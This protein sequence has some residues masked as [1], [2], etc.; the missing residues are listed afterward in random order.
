MSSITPEALDFPTRWERL[1]SSHQFLVDMEVEMSN[2]PG[3]QT[4]LVLDQ[5]QWALILLW[6]SHRKNIKLI[7]AIKEYHGQD[8][9][10]YGQ[11]RYIA[12]EI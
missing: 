7:S 5:N 11:L 3:F 1:F 8:L 4:Q 12:T 6:F 9:T 2:G 10:H